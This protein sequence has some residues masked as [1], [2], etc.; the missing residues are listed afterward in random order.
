MLYIMIPVMLIAARKFRIRM[1]IAQRKQRAMMG[2]LNATIEDSI[3][4]IRVTKSFANED[5]EKKRFDDENMRFLETKREYYKA[6]AGFN[7]VTRNFDG[8]MYLIVIIAGGWCM[9]VSYTHLTLPTTLHE[10]RSRWSPY[11]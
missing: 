11:H 1:L 7:A 4:G 6:M 2:D 9:T 3:S 5:I 10:C 8:I